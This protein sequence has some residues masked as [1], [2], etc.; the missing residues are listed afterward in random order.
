MAAVLQSVSSSFCHLP[1]C[2]TKTSW[3]PC[4]FLRMWSRQQTTARRRSERRGREEEK[5]E[6]EASIKLNAWDSWSAWKTSQICKN[7]KQQKKKTQKQNKKN[8][9]RLFLWPLAAW[10]L[11]LRLPCLS[12]VVAVTGTLCKKNAVSRPRG[13]TFSWNL[14]AHP[15]HETG[16]GRPWKMVRS[17]R[18]TSTS[19]VRPRPK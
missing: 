6:K 3:G 7:I 15:R 1:S 8:V 10:L 19:S 11:C 4:S 5:V 16:P 18:Q 13:Q 9:L 17:W 12:L 14:T 2:R